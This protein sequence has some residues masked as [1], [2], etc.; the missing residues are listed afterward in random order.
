[1]SVYP[2]TCPARQRVQT[3]KS[4]ERDLLIAFKFNYGRVPEANRAGRN[5]APDRLSGLFQWTRLVRVL[6]Q[7]E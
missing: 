3:W 2:V 7:Y 4:L 1:M 6:A 5:F